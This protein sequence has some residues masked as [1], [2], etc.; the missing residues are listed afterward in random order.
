MTSE[1][2]YLKTKPP[3]PSRYIRR[4]RRHRLAGETLTGFVYPFVPSERFG[5]DDGFSQGSPLLAIHTEGRKALVTPEPR[6][7]GDNETSAK[8][9]A[10]W[11]RKSMGGSCSESGSRYEICLPQRIEIRPR[12][13][14]RN[15][16]V[17]TNTTL[18]YH[19]IDSE[20]HA[21][22]PLQ[23]YLRSSS[24]FFYCQSI[25]R[26]VNCMEDKQVNQS[27][28]RTACPAETIL[29]HGA[30]IRIFYSAP[31]SSSDLCLPNIQRILAS[32]SAI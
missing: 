18:L 2:Q 29:I 17:T 32:S 19:K 27:Q 8:T 1:Y 21:D 28:N 13:G 16:P 20:I 23:Q 30:K 22:E 11:L 9:T 5:A 12:W 4:T 14:M 31:V 24:A 10:A 25:G 15:T 7:Q 6:Q 3:C 26:K